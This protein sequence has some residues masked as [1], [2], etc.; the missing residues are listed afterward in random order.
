LRGFYQKVLSLFQADANTNLRS[1]VYGI[2][3]NAL[4]FPSPSYLGSRNL[5]PVENFLKQAYSIGEKSK[6]I[7]RTVLF[8]KQ[9][10]KRYAK[11]KNAKKNLIFGNSIEYITTKFECKCRA[12]SS[13][14]GS[15]KFN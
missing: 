11:K 2:A 7:C 1:K 14:A 3:S 12:R 9:I 6:N 10:P 8:Y 5:I 13:K 4:V 15:G